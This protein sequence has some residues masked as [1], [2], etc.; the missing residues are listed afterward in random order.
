MSGRQKR[1]Y[2]NVTGTAKTNVAELFVAE[3]FMIMS[4]NGQLLLLNFL[5]F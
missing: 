4:T 1:V 5:D 2:V 3:C